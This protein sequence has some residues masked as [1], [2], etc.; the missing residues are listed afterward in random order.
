[1]YELNNK[2]PPTKKPSSWRL[3]VRIHFLSRHLKK[4]VK[5]KNVLDLGCGWGFYL[6]INPAAY[7]IDYNISAIKY[8]SRL[9]YKVK[10]WNILEKL[11][12]PDSFFDF[13]LTHDVLEHFT[14]EEV[15]KIFE[16]V[17][18]VLKKD[19]IFMNVVPNKICYE[20]N[21]KFGVGHKHFVTPEE[22]I[23]IDKEHFTVVKTYPYPL[24]RFIGKYFIHNKE[25]VILKKK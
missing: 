16:N 19:G 4:T 23:E 9:G 20:I 6:R 5:Y 2:F 11:P 8:L 25:V 12:F 21:L 17:Y 1:M 14:F 10:R 24:P 18:Y 22:I 13:V 15:K 3:W 7:G